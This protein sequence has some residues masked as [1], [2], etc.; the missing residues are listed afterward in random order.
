M[1]LCDFKNKYRIKKYRIKIAKDVV[2]NGE[3]IFFS[4]EKGG[5]TIGNGTRVNS[6][7]IYNPIGGDTRSILRTIGKGQIKIGNNVGISNSSL[8][9]MSSIEIEDDVRIGGSCKIYDNDFHS[10]DYT[11]R[12]E[13]PDTDIKYASILIKKGAFIGADS[14]ILKGVTIGEKS[15]IGAGSVVTKNIPNGEI[16]A[17]NPARFIKK[18]PSVGEIKKP[19][20]V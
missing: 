16:W 20:I 11:H 14:L 18:I 7:K 5:I 9:A 2:L 6:G 19:C 15:V 12:L 13:N 1:T 10:I 17:G 3:V 8:I 4:D